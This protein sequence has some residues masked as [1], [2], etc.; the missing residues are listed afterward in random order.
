MAVFAQE[1]SLLAARVMKIFI[2]MKLFTGHLTTRHLHLTI[3]F[4]VGR[5]T[6]SFVKL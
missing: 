6:S 2:P 3:L 5:N 4:L 1:T